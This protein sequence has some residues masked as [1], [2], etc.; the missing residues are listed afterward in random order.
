MTL[1]LEGFEVTG[2]ANGREA[3]EKVRSLLPDLV[4]TDIQ[5]PAMGGLEVT[6]RL[7]ED[8]A[9]SRIPVLIMSVLG[10]K[11]AIVKGLDA[12][13]V[14]YII[15]PFFLPELKA[16]V[17]SVLRFKRV[18]DDLLAMREDLVRRRFATALGETRKILHETL[19][20]NVAVI[21]KDLEEIRRAIQHI[22]A[23]VGNVDFFESVILDL[24]ARISDIAEAAAPVGK[25]P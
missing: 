22:N 16:R 12:G 21:V 8:P 18:Q 15:K 14:D 2:A 20:Q 17:R 3:L 9:T 5:M 10:A 13:A 1:E 23:T 7:R 19:E 24:Y 11:E 6:R 25:A 4:L